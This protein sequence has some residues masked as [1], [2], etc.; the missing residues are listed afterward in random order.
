M[1]RNY[2]LDYFDYFLNEAQ[3]EGIKNSYLSEYLTAGILFSMCQ[4]LGRGT[5]F[6][7]LYE[8]F[9]DLLLSPEF[10]SIKE[11]DINKII[12]FTQKNYDLTTPE[13]NALVDI[14]VKE[15]KNSFK[16]KKETE[17]R[18]R[19]PALVSAINTAYK[20]CEFF[21]NDSRIIEN[22]YSIGRSKGLNNLVVGK[23][24]LVIEFKGKDF[25]GISLKTHTASNFSAV[26]T[27]TAKDWF[28]SNSID[29]IIKGYD[30]YLDNYVFN[31]LKKKV[32]FTSKIAEK[33]FK[34]GK[35]ATKNKKVWFANVKY[36][37]EPSKKST[38][39]KALRQVVLDGLKVPSKFRSLLIKEIQKNEK[40]ILR[41]LDSILKNSNNEK[42]I[43][44]LTITSRNQE[45]TS[46]VRYEVF[47]SGKIPVTD[48]IIK[49]NDN[50]FMDNINDLSVKV[51]T[52]ETDTLTNG[53][54]YCSVL[55][56]ENKRIY[57]L[58]VRINRYTNITSLRFIVSLD[59]KLIKDETE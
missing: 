9:D 43:E 50:I 53:A 25:F 35:L 58:A 41:A 11:L 32:E 2:V 55:N 14:A 31:E 54:I 19:L 5:T 28:D 59:K 52:N 47:K 7:L 45:R 4:D 8:S 12:T 21:K 18:Y 56:K 29:N 15:N 42:S 26:T 39:E 1:L 20:I 10:F 46:N 51:D 34:S 17:G 38:L 22:I 49:K 13:H 33:E 40:N 27:F 57:S 16:F 37:E 23:S 36:K 30:E 24:D 44:K 48:S 3:V 6:K